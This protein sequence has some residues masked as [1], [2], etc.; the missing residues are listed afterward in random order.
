M[1]SRRKKHFLL[2]LRNFV[3][4]DLPREAEP[5]LARRVS[6]RSSNTPLRRTALT[7]R[8]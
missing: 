1:A 7:R 2:W 4:L 6:I 3:A 8:R 5:A